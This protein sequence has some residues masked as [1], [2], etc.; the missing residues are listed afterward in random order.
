MMQ[1]CARD[2]AVAC[3]GWS[4]P[5]KVNFKLLAIELSYDISAGCVGDHAPSPK[6]R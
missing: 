3:E 1:F 4:P 2:A 6:V 5:R